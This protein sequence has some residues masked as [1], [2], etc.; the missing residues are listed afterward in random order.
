MESQ[1]PTQPIYDAGSGN[2]TRDT[3]MEGERSHHC[4]ISATQSLLLRP[5]YS[6]TLEKRS[7]IAEFSFTRP[8]AVQIHWNKTKSVMDG[9]LFFEWG[10]GKFPKHSFPAKTAEKKSRKGSH[11][12][13]KSSKCILLSKSSVWFKKLLSNKKVMPDLKLK[14]SSWP[15]I[16]PYP[17]SKT[18]WSLL[19]SLAIRALSAGPNHLVPPCQNE[20]SCE[21][22]PRENVLQVDSFWSRGNKI[23]WKWPEFIQEM[24]TSDQAGVHVKAV[25]TSLNTTSL[26]ISRPR[27][28]QR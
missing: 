16:F 12:E 3:L 6:S 27:F 24:G 7:L 14:K 23:T 15:K 8:A 21:T 2:Q 20:F 10:F 5:S 1:Q 11:E 9:P 28:K 19:S 4:A 22:D 25:L 18:K 13:K 26:S 17:P